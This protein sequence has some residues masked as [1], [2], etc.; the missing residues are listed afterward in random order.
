ML[1][2][3]MICGVILESVVFVVFR[4]VFV[5]LFLIMIIVSGFV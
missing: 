2:V 3:S 5:F 1:F 4:N